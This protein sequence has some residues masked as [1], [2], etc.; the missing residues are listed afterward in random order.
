MGADEA[1]TLINQLLWNCVL[2][3]GPVLVTTLVVGLVIS[4]IQVATQLQEMTL[5]FIPKMIAAS[6]V[7]A[8]FGGWM[9]HRI[10]DFA[11]YLIRLIPTL[12]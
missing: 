3:A 2:V 5:S 6:L 7:V 11:T 10:T 8:M 1:Q 12:S 4:V 9:L